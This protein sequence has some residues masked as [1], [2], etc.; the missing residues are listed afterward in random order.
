MSA[1]SIRVLI[2][3]AFAAIAVSACGFRLAGTASLPPELGKIELLAGNLDRRQRDELRARLIRAGAEVREESFADAVRLVV[4]L[5]TPP[6]RRIVASSSRKTV[7]RVTRQL[8]F[9]LSDA[10]GKTLAPP[11]TLTQQGDVIVD[12]DNLLSS[13]GEKQ[14][15]VEDLERSLFDR[16]LRQLARI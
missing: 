5:E 12:D 10:E 6:D 3:A 14:T 11:Q 4:S 15:V 1:E 13:T 8:K 16:L 7:N 2:F 9:S